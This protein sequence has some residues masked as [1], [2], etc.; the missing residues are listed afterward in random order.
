MPHDLLNACP[1]LGEQLVRS[2]KIDFPV[3]LEILW[4]KTLFPISTGRHLG[5]EMDPAVNC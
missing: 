3:C 4:L 5:A 1:N 2:G